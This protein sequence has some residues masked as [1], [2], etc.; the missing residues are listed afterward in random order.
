MRWLAGGLLLL[1]C[2]STHAF[3]LWALNAHWGALVFISLNILI[4]AAFVVLFVRL[5]TKS[6]GQAYRGIN[7]CLRRP[8]LAIL[9]I[10]A[11]SHGTAYFPASIGKVHIM[12]SWL[13]TCEWVKLVVL[14]SAFVYLLRARWRILDGCSLKPE[15][16]R[17]GTFEPPLRELVRVLQADGLSQAKAILIAGRRHHQSAESIG[18]QK[19]PERRRVWMERCLWML[20]GILIYSITET[21]ITLLWDGRNMD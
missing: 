2:Y 8:L 16:C 15:Q 21:V 1:Q 9:G 11:L 14:I 10:V 12:V 18:I 17:V 6:S 13:S 3:R 4:M 5:A 19:N 20:T 7:L